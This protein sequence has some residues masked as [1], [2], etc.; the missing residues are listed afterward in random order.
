MDNILELIKNT[1][2]FKKYVAIVE[3]YS[4]LPTINRYKMSE[5]YEIDPATAILNYAK[6][7]E[8]EDEIAIKVSN[9]IGKMGTAEIIGDADYNANLSKMNDDII[10]KGNISAKFS[11][12]NNS[13]F[14]ENG[15]SKK[16]DEPLLEEEFEN[17]F[18]DMAYLYPSKT[19]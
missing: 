3:K 8:K 19:K 7:E 4:D 16:I 14:E 15:I 12:Y 10:M 18:K 13:M 2:E 1:E 9:L 17:K 5:A 6:I 11:S